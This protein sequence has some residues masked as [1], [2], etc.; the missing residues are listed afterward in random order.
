MSFA[1]TTAKADREI[2]QTRGPVNNSIKSFVN[3]KKA[4]NT[5]RRGDRPAFKAF[6]SALQVSRPNL[7][8][9]CSYQKATLE[10]PFPL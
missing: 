7:D 8:L 10:A 5:V 3:R 4:F 6:A 2:K 9:S 1:Q